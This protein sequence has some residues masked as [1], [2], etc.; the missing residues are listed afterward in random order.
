MIGAIG[1]IISGVSIGA[2]A[3]FTS[4]RV[5]FGIVCLGFFIIV[6]LFQALNRLTLQM[7][8]D[9]EVISGKVS[10]G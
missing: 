1:E 2:I 6:I 3:Q 9:K 8:I 4:I 7:D 5:S 10:K